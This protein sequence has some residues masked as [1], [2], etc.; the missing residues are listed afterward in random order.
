MR[1]I[2]LLSL[3]LLSGQW[4]RIVAQNIPEDLDITNEFCPA[5]KME[6]KQRNIIFE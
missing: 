4:N 2:I 6:L 1:T 5:F 3:I